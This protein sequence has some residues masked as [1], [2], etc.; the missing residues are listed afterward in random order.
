MWA[1]SLVLQGSLG[2][3]TETKKTMDKELGFEAAILPKCCSIHNDTQSHFNVVWSQFGC[4][5]SIIEVRA[6]DNFTTGLHA[7][8]GHF[9]LLNA[10]SRQSSWL[11]FIF[12][13][14]LKAVKIISCKVSHHLVYQNVTCIVGFSTWET[15]TTLASPHLFSLGT[16]CPLGGCSSLLVSHIALSHRKR[17]RRKEGS[18]VKSHGLCLFGGDL[19][20]SWHL[21]QSAA[22]RVMLFFN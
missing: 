11:V 4:I 22:G 21:L 16:G 3:V 8:L 1:R 17:G 15:A 20:L 10:N 13:K 6:D 14:V 9:C 18:G 2:W 5:S 12:Y 7:C 19:W